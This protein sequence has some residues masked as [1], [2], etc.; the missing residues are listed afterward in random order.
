MLKKYLLLLILLISATVSAQLPPPGCKIYEVIDD[1]NDGFAAFDIHY[2]VETYFRSIAVIEH[3][4]DLSGYQLLLYPSEED[5]NNDTNPITTPI[6]TNVDSHEQFCW[7]K[8]IYSGSG[9]EYPIG[10]L[11]YYSTCETLITIPFDGDE[12]LDGVNNGLEDLDNNK[13]LLDNDTDH[14]GVL[15]FR[16][17]DDDNDG[18]LTVDE[19][20][21]HNGNYLDDDTNSNEIPDYLDNTATLAVTKEAINSFS[22]VPN[23]ASATIN[24]VFEQL[25]QQNF[26]WSIGDVTGKIILKSQSQS[27]QT[28]DIEGLKSGVYFLTIRMNETSVVKKLMVL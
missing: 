15:N 26:S 2:Y 11:M 18:V 28:I 24:I 22:I 3:D 21:N 10:D 7:L 1:D 17:A 25:P 12:D 13:I 4:Y 19:D 14:D 5:Y 23:P 20:Y 16:D 27:E 6:Y 8:Y 9:P